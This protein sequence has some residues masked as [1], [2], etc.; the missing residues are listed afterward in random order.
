MK[1][2]YTFKFNISM[3]TITHL[4]SIIFL[5]TIEI[6]LGQAQTSPDKIKFVRQGVRRMI[7]DEDQSIPL[8][9]LQP[10]KIIGLK[11]MHPITHYSEEQANVT[12]QE[13][14]L[15]IQSELES[16][17]RIWFGGF[18][19]FATYTIDLISTSGEEK[20][21]LNFL[22]RTSNNNSSSR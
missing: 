10:D 6:N 1:G 21:V 8:A 17:T 16:Q 19:P 14:K 11:V 2:I 20:L 13:D 22:V 7:F 18:N 15:L 5:I 4:I 9:R 3:K 12:I